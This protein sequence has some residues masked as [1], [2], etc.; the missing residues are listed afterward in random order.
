MINSRQIETLFLFR[1]K[2]IQQ[3]K[4][5]REIEVKKKENEVFGVF[6][7]RVQV[8]PQGRRVRKDAQLHDGHSGGNLPTFPNAAGTF[9]RLKQYQRLA[10]AIFQARQSKEAQ[11][12]R[13]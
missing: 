2:I 3:R 6:R 7:R 10:Q 8:Q 5:W 11:F 13:Q 1:R 4:I 12:V 9:S